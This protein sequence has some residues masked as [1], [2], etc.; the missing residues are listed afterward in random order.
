MRLTL[1]IVAIVVTVLCVFIVG[2]G[3]GYMKATERMNI[4][5]SGIINNSVAE[6]IEC[7][8]QL[9]NL[10]KTGDYGIA[11]RQLESFLDVNLGGLT[12][13]VSNPPLKPNA[14]VVDAITIAKRYREQHPGH[15][16]N[17]VMEK[18]VNKTLEFV[19]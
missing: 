8:V 1:K 5:Y 11:Q 14:R 12:L 16:I 10:L 18:S 19:K 7:Q 13:Y 15:K 3:F 6:E 9:L 4:L 17:P 2:A